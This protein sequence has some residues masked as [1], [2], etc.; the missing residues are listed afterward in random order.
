MLAFIADLL[1]GRAARWRA[2]PA[3][4]RH[5][6][7]ASVLSGLVADDDEAGDLAVAD[8]EVVG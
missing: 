6:Y 5:Q 1:P 4:G 2:A 3:L 8:A 7:P